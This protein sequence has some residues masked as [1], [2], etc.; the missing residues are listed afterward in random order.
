MTAPFELGGTF[1]DTRAADLALTLDAA[2]HPAL[3]TRT[4]RLGPFD[5]ELR[6]LGASHQVTVGVPLLRGRHTPVRETLACLPGAEPFLPAHWTDGDYDFHARVTTHD[7]PELARL[8]AGLQERTASA[9]GRS[10]GLI[11][12]YPG[13]PLAVTAILATLDNGPTLRWETWH[14]YPQSG[15]LVHTASALTSGESGL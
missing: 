1:V 6:L 8:V 14:S 9:D 12:S 10:L 3:A 2:E 15:E 4:G 13:R 5:V 11:G 7:E